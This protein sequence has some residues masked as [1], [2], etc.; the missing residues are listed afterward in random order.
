MAKNP[1]FQFYPGDWLRDDIAGAS[2]AAQGLWLRMMMV[3]HDSPQ[4]GYL[5]DASGKPLKNEVIARRCGCT[6]AEYEEYSKQLFAIGVP[7]QNEAGAIYSRRMVRDAETRNGLSGKRKSAGKLGASKRWG[8]WQTDGKGHGKQDGKSI[9]NDGSSSSSSTSTSL[10]NRL[11]TSQASP[12]SKNQTELENPEPEAEP[13][14]PDFTDADRDVG[15]EG[16]FVLGED[17]KPKSPPLKPRVYTVDGMVFEYLKRST[18]TGGLGLGAG[19]AGKAGRMLKGNGGSWSAMKL[20]ALIYA[21]RQ[22]PP[23]RDPVAMAY[24]HLRGK[25]PSRADFEKIENEAAEMLRLFEATC[26]KRNMNARPE[27][28]EHVVR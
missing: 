19:I 11:T 3:M 23:P 7:S 5:C 20:G 21:C 12:A 9:A 13:A 24:G 8:A 10:N 15:V 4:Y 27:N 22:K 1:A 26:R 17:S 6:L 16:R 28:S 2:L 18:E 14:Q 25:T